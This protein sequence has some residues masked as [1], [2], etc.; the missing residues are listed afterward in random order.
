MGVLGAFHFQGKKGLL[1]MELHSY[2]KNKG[3]LGEKEE[4][5][6]RNLNIQ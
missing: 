6:Q 2:G 5:L 4:R 1:K 3:L